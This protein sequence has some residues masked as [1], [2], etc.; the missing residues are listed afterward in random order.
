MTALEA[1]EPD[2]AFKSDNLN[3][4]NTIII[5]VRCK[6][7]EIKWEFYIYVYSAVQNGDSRHIFLFPI[8]MHSYVS[9]MNKLLSKNPLFWTERI[10]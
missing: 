5:V 8:E 4:I 7:V 1:I 9:S 2:S 6:A 3:D 10:P